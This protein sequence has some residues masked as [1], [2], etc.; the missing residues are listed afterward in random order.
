MPDVRYVREPKAGL[1]FARNRA[2]AEA[3]G[4]LVAF[5]DDDIVADRGWFDGLL[6]AARE[7]P[8]A[9]LFTGAVLPYELET[10]AQIIFER[11][12]GFRRGF[13]KIRYQGETL[14]GNPLYPVVAGLFGAGANMVVRRDVVL[15][16]GGFDEALDTGA[17]LPGGGDLDIFYRV[18]RAGRAL[19]YEPRMLVF[20]KH[21]R[22]LEALRRQYWTWGTGFM[23]Y[24][25]KTYANDPS[26]R[27]R[28]RQ[29]IRW[30][31]LHELRHAQAGPSGERASDAEPRPRG[32]RRRHGGTRGHLRPLGPALSGHRE[33]R[34]VSSLEPLDIVHVDLAEGLDAL[35]AG[36]GERDVYAVF[37][38]RD[39]PLGHLHVAREQ[40]AGGGAPLVQL[41]ANRITPAVANRLL[42]GFAGEAPG[43]EDDEAP[44]DLETLVGLTAPLRQLEEA[45][46]APAP[47]PPQESVS[48]VVCTRDRPA[49]LRECLRS[50]RDVSARAEEV[51]VVDNSTVGS[52]RDVVE[53]FPEATYVREARPGLSRARN[54]G[55]RAASGTLIAFT[56]DDT[57]VHPEWLT[58]LRSAFA[59]PDVMVVTGL[60]L[61]AALETE[62]QVIFELV[63]G[64]FFRGYQRIVY[65]RAFFE[66]TR[67]DPV[68]VWK[69]GAGANM[70]VRREAFELVGDFDERLGAGAA[71][72]ART[73]SSGTAFSPRDGAASTSP[74][75]SSSTATGRTTRPCAASCTSTCAATSPRS[76]CSTPATGTGATSPARSWRLP[77][78]FA[79]R[80]V[81]EYILRSRPSSG[82]FAPSLAGYLR[83]LRLAPLA[84]RSSPRP[85]RRTG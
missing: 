28:I 22:S 57:T 32:A 68:P 4:E 21:R 37:W 30:W 78:D 14:P 6:E 27:A 51:I 61:P 55:I 50:L 31:V 42:P 17:P 49:V 72:A 53:E 48:V 76:S 56:D 3:G 43:R 52:M 80:A 65:D 23:A 2:L 60:V 75:R 18:V 85:G 71:G 69:I 13:E 38:W 11:R 54:T 24:I 8:D 1:D 59:E 41:I 15:A 44:P 10:E 66:Q 35:T 70:A 74:A 40:L 64:G 67:D 79:A 45:I 84:R 82:T 39:V 62:S 46:A 77:R 16:L 83:G 20:H 73:R 29:A 5:L 33:A 26:Q 19:V 58:R 81:R 47:E 7:N 9:A 12:G 25:S 63:Y 34:L 36:P